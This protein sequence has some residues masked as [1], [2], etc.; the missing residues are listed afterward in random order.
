VR[1]YVHCHEIRFQMIFC[2]KGWVRVV[3]EDQGPPFVLRAGDCVLQPPRIR[4]RVLESSEGLEVIEVTSPAEHETRV[5]HDLFLPTSHVYANRDF[6]GQS[7]LHHVASEG[8]WSDWRHEGFE[9]CDMGMAA[10]TRG[11]AAS[12]VVRARGDGVSSAVAS[13]DGEF[14]FLCVIQG[15]CRLRSDGRVDQRMGPG[16]AT[17]VPAGMPY[18]LKECSRDLELLEVCLPAT[19]R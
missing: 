19:T 11:L 5:D 3:Y 13:H 7:F 12:C 1:D 2:L 9:A 16:E 18:A 17:V 14:L 10:A 15:G 8:R 6:G 4:H